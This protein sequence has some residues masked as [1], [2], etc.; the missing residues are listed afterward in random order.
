MKVNGHQKKK[1]IHSHISQNTILTNIIPDKPIWMRLLLNGCLPHWLKPHWNWWPL[2]KGQGHSHVISIFFFITLLT[3]LLC[4]SALLCSIK[5][6]SVC[7]LDICLVDLCLNFIKMEWVITSLWRH[8]SFLQTIVN[9]LKFYQTYKL[10][11]HT[12]NQY[13]TTEHSSNE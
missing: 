3:S 6:K 13:T 7:R 1:R 12:W 2:V 5:M 8:L 4:I 11:M 10:R 9:I